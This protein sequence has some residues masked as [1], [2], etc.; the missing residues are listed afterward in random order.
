MS[1]FWNYNTVAHTEQIVGYNPLP[2]Q[3]VYAV[4]IPYLLSLF[5]I[6]Y[7]LNK[8]Q[9][10]LTLCLPWI[11]VHPLATFVIAPLLNMN[12][13]RFFLTAYF[14][15]FA[16]LATAGLRYM[17]ELIRTWKPIKNLTFRVF[18]GAAIIVIGSGYFAYRDSYQRLRINF[19]TLLEEST[20]GYPKKELMEAVWW[21]RDHTQKN[22]IVLADPYA[23]NLIP[24]F[25]GN[26]VYTSWWF[27]LDSPEL[28]TDTYTP[29]I[30]FYT[31]AM[32][33][34]EASAFL[35]ANSI[36]YVILPFK[37]DTTFTPVGGVTYRS[38]QETFK[39]A[40]VAVYT[41]Q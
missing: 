18:T 2:W 25:A 21:L 28:F 5:A 38:L 1:Q 8:K 33:D 29:V 16:I 39:N 24:A 22:D 36:S 35:H 12:K 9:T 30:Q 40:T 27:W 23:G 32:T 26:R 37:D 34:S 6:P 17:A 14:V 7:V 41:V 19:N 10:F 3:Y 4:G 11:I 15:V 31:G 13:S 20:F